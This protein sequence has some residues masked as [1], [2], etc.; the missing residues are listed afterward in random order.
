ML[1][2][3]DPIDYGDFAD[4]GGCEVKSFKLIMMIEV[5]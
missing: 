5:K 1:V 4:G 2:H 3:E